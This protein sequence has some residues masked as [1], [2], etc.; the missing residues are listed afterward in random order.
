MTHEK[1]WEEFIIALRAY[2]EEHHHCANKHTELYNKTRY[3]R[4]RM[5]DGQLSPDKAKM[6][7]EILSMRDLSE[8]TGGRRKREVKG[9]SVWQ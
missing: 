9:L 7:E 3:Y 8:H 6:L 4:R 2:I 5:K 1:R